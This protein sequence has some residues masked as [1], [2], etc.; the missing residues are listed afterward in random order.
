VDRSSE[1]WPKARQTVPLAYP[2]NV[3]DSIGYGMEVVVGSI[4]NVEDPP[5]A[6]GTPQRSKM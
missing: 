1:G 6:D 4:P 3:Y 2:N 5:V